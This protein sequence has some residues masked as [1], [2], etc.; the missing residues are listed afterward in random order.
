[1]TIVRDAAGGSEWLVGTDGFRR[2]IPTPAD[3]NCF[4]TVYGDPVV[5]AS[6]FDIQ[7]LPEMVG[8]QATCTVTSLSDGS[9][10]TYQGA[11]YEIVG[12][13][14]VYVSSWSAVGGTHPTTAL[15]DAG[16]NTLA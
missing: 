1:Q 6:L 16:W 12:H 9:F 5:V 4:Q 8:A 13:A 14:P 10:V 11:T 3:S 15:S 2:S 7:T